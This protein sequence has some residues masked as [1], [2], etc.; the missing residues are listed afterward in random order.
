MM[1]CLA[2]SGQRYNMIGQSVK[3]QIADSLSILLLEGKGGHGEV[4][5]TTHP[6]YLIKVW[7]PLSSPRTPAGLRET[8]E[9]YKTFSQL[10]F[11][12]ESEL[13]CL[14]LE[15]VVV[16]D[17][18]SYVMKRASGKEMGAAWESLMNL[19]LVARLLIAQSLAK[20][21]SILHSRD[22]VHADIKPDNFFF[23]PQKLTV[24]VL[25]VDGGGYYGLRP[26]TKQFLPSA[27][28]SSRYM[29][30]EFNRLGFNYGLSWNPL[31]QHPHQR[32]QPDLWALASLIYEIIVDEE[33]PFPRTYFGRTGFFSRQP[34]WPALTQQK[35]FSSLGIGNELLDLFTEVFCSANRTRNDFQRPTAA[36]WDAAL[37][38]T[39]K[40]ILPVVP[41]CPECQSVVLEPS[42]RICPTCVGR[43]N[44]I[45]PLLTVISTPPSTTSINIAHPTSAHPTHTSSMKSSS[46]LSK[47]RLKIG[48]LV[49][50]ITGLVLFRVPDILTAI[51]R[52]TSPS[53]VTRIKRLDDDHWHGGYSNIDGYD[54]RSAIWIYGT[55]TR[56]HTMQAI[57][58][59][60]SQPTGTVT[61]KV[62]GMDS[63]GAAKTP[64]SIHVN[65]VQV[66]NGPNSLPNGN[67]PLGTGTW[68]TATWLFDAKLL[69]P[70]SNTISINNL[71]SG[72]FNAPPWFMLDYATLTLSNTPSTK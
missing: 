9:R 44:K 56:Y 5:Q 11:I 26:K 53:L 46:K 36:L 64:I 1:R 32:K 23:D 15:F 45:V 60:D 51:A 28:P 57:F 70:G 3:T 42:A 48:I 4:Y 33:G 37:D 30:P 41:R 52:P 71:A 34:E 35:K 12:Y 50:V 68:A 13:P 25:D 38:K 18:P 66:Y 31:W 67:P 24:E 59:L 14:P 49:L 8:E 29:A 10:H 58:I 27:I 21:I 40:R 2:L 22:V 7:S 69:H 72:A 47:W 39:I 6:Q 20:G 19:D 43:F 54:G 62:E 16:K 63:E 55:T 17:I 65:G 61:F